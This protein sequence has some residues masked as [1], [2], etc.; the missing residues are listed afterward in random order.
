MRHPKRI[1]W[2][3]RRILPRN[4]WGDALYSVGL[5]WRK[6]RRMPRL[7]RPTTFNEKLLALKLSGE[8][9]D[10]LR[11]F[12]SDK[13]FLKDFV[14]ARLSDAYNVKT[15]AVFDSIDQLRNFDWPSDCVVKPTHLSGELVIRRNGKPDISLAQMDGWL[16][17]NYY[18]IDRERNYRNLKSKIIVEDLLLDTTENIPNDYKIFC[19]S[20]KPKFIQMDIDRFGRHQRSSYSLNWNKL[21]FTS[22]YPQAQESFP[23]PSRLS[24]MIEVASRLARGLKF[25]RIDLYAVG[26]DIKVGEMTSW[27]GNGVSPFIPEDADAVVG[28]LFDDP[29]ADIE[30][31]FASSPGG[32]GNEPTES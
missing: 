11:Q 10:P 22:L 5:Y 3:M 14:R 16:R 8:S 26:N 1:S 4:R 30:G 31:L 18:D 23:R 29:D 24:D 15:I 13:E 6:H 27:P 28:R 21:P 32:D 7:W 9:L 2:L 12:V 19:F 25:V 17:T 20:G